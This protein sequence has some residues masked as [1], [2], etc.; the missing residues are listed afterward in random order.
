MSEIIATALKNNIKYH[1]NVI[2]ITDTNIIN[3]T[4]KRI[5]LTG[6]FYDS[7]HDD[8]NNENSNFQ[9]Y[10]TI[11]EDPTIDWCFDD[12]SKFIDISEEEF[13]GIINKYKDWNFEILYGLK[14][15]V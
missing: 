6:N 4:N 3:N 12:K 14:G 7:A 13:T 9:V 10:E 15:L 8:S 2:V 1:G 5:I 11:C